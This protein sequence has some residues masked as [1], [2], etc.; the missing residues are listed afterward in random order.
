M[1][2]PS[3]V[4]IVST[5]LFAAGCSNNAPTELNGMAA[6]S[7]AEK[8]VD[9]PL[10]GTWV[11]PNPVNLSEVQGFQLNSDGSASSVNM[12]TLLYR[13]W[14]INGDSLNLV[15]ESIGNQVSFI[16]TLGYSVL[17]CDGDTLVLRREQL[18]ETYHK[19]RSGR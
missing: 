12:A 19:N 11:Q 2:L 14:W 16:D 6:D 15:V 3:I 4:I 13:N 10:V 8:V 7:S 17:R 1:K 9:N 18:T 5:L